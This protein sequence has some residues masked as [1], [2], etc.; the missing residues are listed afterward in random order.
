MEPVKLRFPHQFFF[1]N[2]FRIDISNDRQFPF[3]SVCIYIN[4]YFI[5]KERFLVV[6]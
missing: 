1:I 3:I 2:I 4:A 6:L 5:A